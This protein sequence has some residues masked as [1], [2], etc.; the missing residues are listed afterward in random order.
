MNI[1]EIKIAVDAMGGDNAP[2]EI[3][4]GVVEFT[5]K[6][7][8]KVILV[9]KADLIYS[10]LLHHDFSQDK[11]DVV[12]APEIISNDDSPT[13]AIKTKKQSSMVIGLHMLKEK[14]VDAFIS[15]GNTG[16][17]VAGGTLIVGRIK[18][19][20][21]PALG[22][23]FP[24]L[25][26]FSL[27]IDC[28]A[29]VDAKPIY[30]KQFAQMG[31]IYFKNVVGV[32]EPRVGLVNIGTEDKKGN[33]LV[34]ESYKLLKNSDLNFTGNLEARNIFKGEADI[35]VC[36]AFVGNIILKH[37]EGLVKDIFGLI[38]KELNSS[39]LSKI[40]GLF[41]IRAFKNIKKVFDYSEYGGAPLL[42]LESLVVKA[43]GSSKS[44]D[45]QAALNQ[46]VKFIEQDIANEIAE[47]MEKDEEEEK[48]EQCEANQ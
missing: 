29:N 5:N 4:K 45:I 35:I 8:I 10:Q 22:A 48:G 41:A 27:L 39:I 20:K 44:S 12:D 47:K 34:R 15:A 28:G 14:T 18:G 23:I 19:V 43:H 36:D 11:I 2:T 1:S 31:S 16:A 42:G 30:L 21:R 26:G 24:T 46:C 38:K 40:G 3:I 6:H 32:K 25:K 37:T 7:N 17:L 33:E 13:E 9:G